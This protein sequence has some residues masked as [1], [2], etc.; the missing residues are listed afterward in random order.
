[1]GGRNKKE[2][3]FKDTILLAL[4][5]EVGDASQRMKMAVEPQKTKK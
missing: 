3:T 4:K 5:I 1:M 2:E